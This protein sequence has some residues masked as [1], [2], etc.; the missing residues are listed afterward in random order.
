MLSQKE[1]EG[2]GITFDADNS[3]D[4]FIKFVEG[5]IRNYLIKSMVEQ[6]RLKRQLA[7]S[8]NGFIVDKIAEDLANDILNLA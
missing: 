2:Q 7:E 6:P 3:A 5:G 4:I 1:L 8:Q